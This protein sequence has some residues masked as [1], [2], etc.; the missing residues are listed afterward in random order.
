MRKK[1]CKSNFFILISC[2][3]T[4]HSSFDQYLWG[5][6]D[7]RVF[8][9]SLESSISL[10][11]LRAAGVDA[12]DF[13]DFDVDTLKKWLDEHRIV[14]SL[15]GDDA[16]YKFT[17]ILS[18]PLVLYE[19]WERSLM[20]RPLLAIVGP[21]KM[22]AYQEKIVKEFLDAAKHYDLVTISGW[23][24]GVD[25]LVHEYSIALGIPTIVVLGSW[26]YHALRSRKREW[27]AWIVAAWW[28]V[29]SEFRLGEK[30]SNRTFPQR[31]RIVAGVAEMVFLPGAGK[32]SGSLITVDFA[33]RMHV[34]VH[35]VPGSFHDESNAWSNEYLSQGLIACAMDFE[36]CLDQY[37][38]KNHIKNTAPLVEL[39]E[40]QQQIL[41][42]LAQAKSI[43]TLISEVDL[44]VPEL[45][46]MLTEL[47]MMGLVKE[48]DGGW[49]N[50]VN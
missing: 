30:P 15:V 21:R 48:G 45:L 8:L 46:W 34:P 39:S 43:E 33:N 44:W 1:S 47:E 10:S 40:K 49:V 28:L 14:P 29:I 25:M 24:E 38:S 6:V 31:N 4:S 19:M 26:F 22:S 12:V 27:L 9:Y 32:K 13:G 17:T 5:M 18:K 20:D 7:R 16:H 37:F 11:Q 41:D 42:A 36:A 3:F 50:W 23:A 35:T 2:S